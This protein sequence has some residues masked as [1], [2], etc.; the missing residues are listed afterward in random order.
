VAEGEYLIDTNI[1]LKVLLEQ[2]NKDSRLNLLRYVEE[3][4]IQAIVTSFALHSI[5]IILEN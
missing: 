5:A 4:K 3:G 1:F 2:D